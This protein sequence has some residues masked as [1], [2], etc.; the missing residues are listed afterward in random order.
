MVGLGFALLSVAVGVCGIRI[1]RPARWE[2][3]PALGLA[4]LPPWAVWAAALRLPVWLCGL[5][6]LALAIVGL[7][8]V[9]VQRVER[10][11]GGLLVI[12]CMVPAV[13]LMTAFSGLEVPVSNH[14][15]AFHVELIDS[16]RR[17]GPAATWYPVGFHASM[18]TVLALMPWLDTARGTLEATQGLAILTPACAFGL[19]LSLGL[20]PIHAAIASV[21]QALTFLFPYDYQL[22]GGWPL[23]MS[24]LLVL[25]L[26][27]VALRWLAGPDWR[28]ALMGGVFAGAILLTHGTEV[29]T[30]LV[31]L[32]VVAAASVR[33]LTRRLPAH[34]G[35][36]A[37]VALAVAAPYIP[38]LL[39]W[40]GRGGASSA[41][42]TNLDFTIAHPELQGHADWLQFGLGITGAGS[43]LDL[44]VRLVLL[45]L[46]IR[47]GV[48]RTLVWL[49]VTFV[50]LLLMVDFLDVPVINRV[51]ALTFPWLV[52]HRPRQ[53]AVT[54]AALI[55][56]GGLLS[57][58]AMLR[59]WRPRYLAGPHVWR[60]TVLACA[61]LIGFVAE[62]S[63]VTIYKRLVN[64]IADQ[65]LY[66]ADDNAAMT[67]LRQHA[68]PGEMLAN[69]MAGD[70]GIWAPYK[71]NVPI[72]LPRT[73]PGDLVEARQRLAANVTELEKLPNAS[74]QACLLG[75]NY[76]YHGARSTPYDPR[77]LPDRAELERAADLTEVFRSGRAVVFRLDL[78]CELAV[79]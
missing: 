57:A 68:R 63:A 12:G 56:A 45:A 13:L 39:H 69:N 23:G 60:R 40:A 44:P 78:P 4:L 61:L 25:G 62:G 49:W 17:G 50:G 55:E 73:A 28:W 29:Y 75:L 74:A 53:I 22:W 30:A 24:V 67:W 65:N 35:L 11:T 42:L 10:W 54:L 32:L 34:L 8:G 71:A 48:P 15:G 46:G 33:G 51:F 6:V 20:R 70:A 43:A 7:V 2:L 36:A 27:S 58:L 76:V 3:A 9:R 37:I 47:A 41:G 19:G 52:D 18:A 16:F 21:I 14:D 38:T 77:L 64:D 72:L 66:L 31:G 1:L 5:S 59:A 79:P 26:W